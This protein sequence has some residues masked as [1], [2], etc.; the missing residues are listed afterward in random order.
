VAP[1]IGPKP[2]G[3]PPQ[4]AGYSG[5]VKIGMDVAASEFMTEDGKYDLNFKNKPNDG[6]EV[7]TGC[8]FASEVTIY[9]V[10]VGH[11]QLCCSVAFL[12]CQVQIASV[13]LHVN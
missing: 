13:Y 6:S 3:V 1:A 8:G 7:K 2:A 5:K 11:Y 4:A 12:V 9:Q 10:V